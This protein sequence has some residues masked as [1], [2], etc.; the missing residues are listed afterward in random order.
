MSRASA[1]TFD[2][3]SSSVARRLDKYERT[4]FFLMDSWNNQHVLM[5]LSIDGNN[6]CTK[7]K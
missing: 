4:L 1:T 5:F 2:E 6:A 7:R 3:T